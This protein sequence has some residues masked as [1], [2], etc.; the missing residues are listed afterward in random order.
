[1]SLKPYFTI[2][3]VVRAGGSRAAGESPPAVPSDA[4]AKAAA[5][6]P[7]PPEPTEWADKLGLR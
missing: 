2:H 3:P 5:A 1:M 7:E 6:G 4:W